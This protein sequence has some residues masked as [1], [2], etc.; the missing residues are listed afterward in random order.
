MLKI[1]FVKNKK[2]FPASLLGYNTKSTIYNKALI[3]KSYNQH[4]NN[5][6]LEFLGDAILTTIISELLFLENT[7]KEEGFLSKKRSEIIARKHLNLVGKKII[8]EHKIKSKLTPIPLNVFGNTLEA[9]VGAIY[10]E[11]GEKEVKKF[12]F[13]HVYNSEFL[14]DLHN[15]DFKS[16]LLKHSQKTKTK[17][18]YKTEEQTGLEHNKTFLV[19]VYI[20]GEKISK[21]TGRSKKEAEQ[22]AAKKALKNIQSHEK[23]S[24]I[25]MFS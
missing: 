15:I 6:R 23:T 11:K 8:P 14:K 4:Y 3:H 7:T 12:V 19:A 20:D 24:H 13:K 25:R 16:T 18:K 22:E 2:T 5:E 1:P 9:I 10:I 17:I 21:A